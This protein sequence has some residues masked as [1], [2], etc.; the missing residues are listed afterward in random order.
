MT[1]SASDDL[2]PPGPAT[3]AAPVR[4][5]SRTAGIVVAVVVVG[6]ILALGGV[7]ASA[8]RSNGALPLDPVGS[9]APGFDLPDLDGGSLALADLSGDPVVLAFWASWCTTCKADVPKL[10]RAV[11]EWGP[12]G[13]TVVG[14]VIDDTFDAAVE[15]ASEAA[16]RYPSVFDGGG[17]VRAAYGVLGTPETYLVDADGRVAAKWL[18]PLPEHELDLALAGI[19]QAGG[20]DDGP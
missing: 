8:Q 9:P 7:L 6:L 5:R 17:E 11:E 10:Q 4:R 15:V 20:A 18:G 2:L 16:H 3:T 19:T 1:H 14:V 12:R 13:V